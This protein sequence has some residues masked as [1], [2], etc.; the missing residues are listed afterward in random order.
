MKPTGMILSIVVFFAFWFSAIGQF[1]V[2]LRVS[3]ETC[4]PTRPDMLGPFYKP[5]APERSSVGKGYVLKG[6]VKSS[7]DCSPIERAQV[8]FWLVGPGGGYDDDHRATVFSEKSG[9]YRFE[10]NFPSGYFGRPEHI[11]I[12]VS[13]QGYK[14]LITQHYPLMG[15]KQGTFDLVLIPVQ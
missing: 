10:S 9:A 8:E 13:A 1:S 15:T 3:A 14:I 12:R 7:R 4:E 11:H 2:P 6:V 5:N